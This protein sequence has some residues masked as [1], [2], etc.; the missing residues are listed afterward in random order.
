MI[1]LGATKFGDQTRRNGRTK[2]LDVVVTEG[3]GVWWDK[4]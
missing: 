2:V 3:P 4:S 1:T